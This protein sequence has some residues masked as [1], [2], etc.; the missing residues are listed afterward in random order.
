MDIVIATWFHAD[1]F[2]TSSQFSQVGG[3]SASVQFQAV[4]WRCILAF[5]GSS[6]RWNADCRHAL[7][8]NMAE[9]PI[10]DGIS[11]EHWL[12]R[13]GIEIICSVPLSRVTPEGFWGAWKNQFYVFDALDALGRQFSSAGTFILLDSDCVW[14]ASHHRLTSVIAR[15]GLALISMPYEPEYV[16][17]GVRVGDIAAIGES[18]LSSKA[19][20][21][22]VYYG[23]EIQALDRKNM[24][25]ILGRIDA[26]FNANLEAYRAGRPYLKEEAQMLSALYAQM[27]IQSANANE[28]IRRIWTGSNYNN[29]LP[30]DNFL[31]ILHLPAEKR[32]GLTLLSRK[33]KNEKSWFWHSGPEEFRRRVARLVGIPRRSILEE[34]WHRLLRLAGI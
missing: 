16:A 12:Q 11:I 31:D 7:V 33:V 5:F 20:G 9:L 32:L 34:F 28:V 19:G 14:V 3:D 23:G 22:S 4:Y 30:S 13:H 24:L 2:R 10:V 17:N 26:L 27:G 21:K 6:L 18:L 8:T 1:D 29:V 25:L 15:D